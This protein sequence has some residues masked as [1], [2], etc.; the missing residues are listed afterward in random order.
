LRQIKAPEATAPDPDPL[1]ARKMGRRIL[2]INGHADPRPERLCAALAAAYAEGA[3]AGGHEVRRIDVGALDFPLIRDAEAFINGKPPADI[4]SAQEAVTW[5][6]HI[7]IVHPLWL[8]A[9]PALLKGFFEQVF[10]YGFAVNP[11][12]KSLSGLL[13]WRSAR[14]VVTMGMPGFIYRSVFGAFGVRAFERGVLGLSGIGPIRRILL[15]GVESASA[16]HRAA[17][18]DRMR[19]LGKAAR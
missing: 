16:E 19:R 8:G 3:E 18:L 4:L 15:G 10:R 13:R 9:A 17:W 12:S 14:I 5:C 1:E 11:G 7:F 6:E 2:V